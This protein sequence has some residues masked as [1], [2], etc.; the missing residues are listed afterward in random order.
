MEK[1]K[2]ARNY[3]SKKTRFIKK[4]KLYERG[5]EV[6][7]KFEIKIRKGGKFSNGYYKIN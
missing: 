3:L 5:I 1:R 7:Q 2:N 6:Y 4:G